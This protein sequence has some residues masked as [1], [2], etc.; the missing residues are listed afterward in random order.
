MLMANSRESGKIKTG[1]TLGHKKP[2]VETVGRSQ[3]N[4]LWHQLATRVQAK[5]TVGAP[6]DPYEREA[7]RVADQ[8]MS[9]STPLPTSTGPAS[10]RIPEKYEVAQTK[11]LASTIT[12][13]AQRKPSDF[14]GS[15]EP[16]ADFES[17]LNASDGGNPLPASMRA[18]MEPRFGAD[19]SG[20][21]VHTGNEA[22]Q[23]NRVI[24]AQAF[25][26]GRDIYLGEGKN[27]LES[28]AGKQLLAHELTHT[29]QQR[30][31]ST[32]DVQRWPWSKPKTPER[33]AYENARDDLK[34]Y[35]KDSHPDTP[36]R[37]RVT[38][39]L[40]RF[41]AQYNA[42]IDTLFVSVKVKFKFID[43]KYQKVDEEDLAR[44][45]ANKEQRAP[46][47]INTVDRWDPAEKEDWKRKFLTLCSSTWSFQ[48]TLYCHKD[49]WESLKANVAATFIEANDVGPA[50]SEIMI[51]KGIGVD[52][53]KVKMGA[54]GEFNQP[55]IEGAHPIAA[56]EAGHM[57][58]L[59]DEYR[60]LTTPEG[61]RANHSGLVRAEFDNEVIRGKADPDS[62]MAQSGAQKV[63][64]QHGVVFLEAIRQVTKISEWHLSP[65]PP[66]PVPPE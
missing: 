23:L 43:E 27:N 49:W 25:T 58:G 42:A 47:L 15:F 65:K 29:I 22:T 28:S 13:I 20:V 52:K 44:I 6:N 8:V 39:A 45:V 16:G 12:S 4:P 46:R 59:G 30:T 26:H 51:H 11:C 37:V 33:A 36:E 50:H 57:L 7:D 1:G 10:V 48:H 18:F 35:R 14:T 38:V 32:K 9:M 60:E 17:H 61:E 56:H 64:P 31:A 53:S 24:N 21:R 41:D 2:K 3:A 34:D 63:L 19:F 54:N 62:I 5:L 40:G 66:R 55:D